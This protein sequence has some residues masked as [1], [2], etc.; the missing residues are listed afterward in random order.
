MSSYRFDPGTSLPKVAEM[1]DFNIWTFNCA[2]LSRHRRLAGAARRPRAH[3]DRQSHHDQ[4]P[5]PSA[6]PP[7]RGDLHRR[8]LGAGERAMAGDDHR[9]AGG[10]DPRHR[11]RRR[12]AGRLGLPLPQVASHHERHGP[13]TWRTS[14]ACGSAISSGALRRA[15]PTAMAMGTDGMADMGEMAMPLPPNTLADD[16]GD[17]ASSGRSRWAACSR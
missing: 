3:Q 14:S 12:R 9:R 8:R 16:D 10:R 11:V 7:F 6:R 15:A 4:P 5:D 17:R 1:T 13:S 2:R